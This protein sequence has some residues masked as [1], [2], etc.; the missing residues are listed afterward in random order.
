MLTSADCQE[1]AH[2]KLAEAEHNPL[3]QR[4]LRNAAEA[5]L[6]L[7]NQLLQAEAA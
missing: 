2:E 5:W 4:R 3:H 6:I 7:A 1:R